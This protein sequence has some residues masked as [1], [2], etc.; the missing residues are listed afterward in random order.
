M[1]L[2][3]SLVLSGC[4]KNF[5]KINTNKAGV[6][7]DVFR[8]DYQQVIQPLR[9][10]QR[11]LVHYVNWEYQLQENLNSDIYSGYMM[12]PTPFNSNSNNATYYMMDGWNVQITTIAY[13]DVMAGITDFH[14][15]LAAYEGVD[16]SDV[17]G[18]AKVLQVIEMHKVSDIFGPII[19]SKYGQSN[20][21]LSVD[22]DTQQEAYNAFFRDLDTAAMDLKP[23]ADGTKEVGTAFKGADLI[24]G[25]DPVKWLKLVNTLRLRLAMHIVYAD[26]ATAK[27]Q[28]EKALDP[29]NGGLIT[30]NA[31]NALVAYGSASPIYDIITAW[32]D[33]RSGAPL[34]AYLNGFH[35]PR[36]THYM[37]PASDPAVAG[38]FIGIRNGVDIDAKSRYANYSSPA[39]EAAVGNYFDGKNG[40]AKIATAAESYFLMAEAALRGWANA[41]DAQTDYETGIAKSFDEWGAGSPAAYIQDATSTEQPYVDPKAKTPGQNNVLAG[42]PNLSTITIKWNSGDSF[43]RKLERIITQKWIALYPDGQEAWT[44]FRRTGYPKLFPVVVNNSNGVITGFINRLPFPISYVSDNKTAYDKVIS[45]LGGPDNGN[46][47]LWW[48]KK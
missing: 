30:D 15:F 25:G 39:A 10:V 42:N 35:D 4:T 7:Q 3:G 36:V 28:G 43:E 21:D 45:N 27:E 18:M 44:E 8:A 34:G 11:A 48:D 31:D 13:N 26:A 17:N 1:F 41:G 33:I 47:K 14:N 32:G 38:E 2:S 6:T 37:T 29:A 22:F 5:E 16:F 19:Y 20:A 23:Y 9:N 46:T 40:L 24:Y 12:T